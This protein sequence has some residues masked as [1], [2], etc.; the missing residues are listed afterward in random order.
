MSTGEAG[1]GVLAEKDQP[2]RAVGLG[3]HRGDRV[4]KHREL[5]RLIGRGAWRKGGQP[6]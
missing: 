5:H 3:L 2:G 4:A 1:A 6:G